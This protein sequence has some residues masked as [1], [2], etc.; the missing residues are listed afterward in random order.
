MIDK[1]ESPIFYDPTRH[2]WRYYKF[3]VAIGSVALSIA[4]IATLYNI[5]TRDNLPELSIEKPTST[6]RI[7]PLPYKPNVQ[8]QST[9]SSDKTALTD[10]QSMVTRKTTNNILSQNVIAQPQQG[11]KPKVI[12]YYVNWD[13]TSFVSLKQNAAKIDGLVP[14]WLHL[15]NPNGSVV[16]DDKSR[17]KSTLVFLKK[18]APNLRITPLINNYDSNK[19]IWDGNRLGLMLDNQYYRARN[20]NNL[21]AYVQNNN[22]QGISIDY[23]NIPHQSQPNFNIFIKELYA[24]FH[25]LNFEVSVNVPIADDS[26]D[27]KTISENSDFVILMAYDEHSAEDI[28]G[29]I[30]SQNWYANSLA[31]VFR[32]INPEKAVI[33]L[34][35]YGYDWVQG[36]ASNNTYS[37]QRS[38]TVAKESEGEITLD[39]EHLNETYTYYDEYD[40]LHQV[41]FLD[42]VTA[43]N[44]IVEGNKYQPRGFAMWRLGSEDPSIWEVFASRTNLNQI[45]ADK[46]K[47]MDYGYGINYEGRGEILKVT[48]TPHTGKREFLVEPGS[49][50]ITK[51]K[52]T[53]FPSPYIINRWGAQDPKKIAITFDDGPDSEYTPQILEILKQHKAPA[54]FFIVGVN[55]MKN[56]WLVE[57]E[58][59]YGHEV[60][61]HTFTH[62]D[63]STESERAFGLELNSVQSFLESTVGRRTLLFRPPYSEDIEPE[64]PDHVKPL[65]QSTSLGYYTVGMHIDP[66]D[67]SRPGVDNIVKN[68]IDSANNGSGNIVLLHDSGGDRSQT[69]E[70]LPK[71]IEGLRARG[72]K[73]VT[74]SELIGA[75]R[76][77]IM[78]SVSGSERY[79]SATSNFAFLLINILF[80]V[81]GFLFSLGIILGSARFIF[82]A[83]LAI[84]QKIRSGKTKYP[85]K[86]DFLP[87]VSVIIPAYNE[88]K[89]IVRTIRSILKS[90]YPFFDIKVVDD[91]S[92]DSTYMRVWKR[93]KNNSKVRVYSKVNGGK[94]SALNLGIKESKSE[95]VITLDADTL[96]LPNTIEKLI[97]HFND[98]RVGA[99]AGNAK[100]GNRLNLL[101]FWQALEYITSQNLDRRAFHV[102]NC[103]TV[104]PGSVG[105]WRRDALLKAGGFSGRTLA[106]DADLTFHLIRLGYKVAY[107]DEA[108]A[109]TEAP[110]NVKNFVKQRFRWMY[111]TLQTAWK[112]KEAINC[113]GCRTLGIVAI[114]NIFI[115]QVV[116]PLI[117]PIMDL[118]IFTSLIWVVWEKYH[119]PLDYSAAYAFQK[120]F[121]FYLFF[122]LVDFV[123]S[124]IAFVLEHKEDWSLMFWMFLQRFFYRQLMYYVAI[125]VT[126][127][128]IKGKMV[129]WGKFER[130]AT[131]GKSAVS[132]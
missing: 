117:S 7:G 97:R 8:F 75:T 27:I 18:N 98:P 101:T 96:F 30:A 118:T 121:Y 82:I 64:T 119:H 57:Q 89:V 73:L 112:H 47:I 4:F 15:S 19:Q 87:K 125:K 42:A 90:S 131:V 107:E 83:V 130:K 23:E 63:I 58:I 34:G 2:R 86:K 22:F 85:A 49:G 3:L 25:P 109:Y 93:F 94:A 99:V 110:D 129:R 79:V 66:K 29:P 9:I 48:A 1:K 69:V 20:I 14:E 104:V 16:L 28:V 68:I 74:V 115:F 59:Y 124:A 31:D 67:W 38:V 100:V 50:L 17:Q 54:T 127:G 84:Y 32:K 65:V 122:L 91:G 132:P 72:Y 76:D 62:P 123:T 80:N 111:G 92:T 116:F 24:K 44:Q 41:Y 56:R 26:F 71:I 103:I 106:E 11:Y 52:I 70:A 37:F 36:E 10:I 114:P 60:A 35:N 81:L 12:A 46:I 6:F 61:S 53:E 102:L 108:I 113:P 95:I 78:P 126:L 51:S 120:L 13:D 88:E 21:L 77:D 33:S 43:F 5:F 40:K 55:A 128:A 45:A 105:A 39:P